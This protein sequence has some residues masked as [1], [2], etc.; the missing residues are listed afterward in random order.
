M[1]HSLAPAVV[2]IFGICIFRVIWVKTVFANCLVLPVLKNLSEW[3]SLL[4]VYPASWVITGTA[5]F[6]LY[7]F[8]S[9]R[10][11]VQG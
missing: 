3:T 2:T 9:R 8:V 5:M 4:I 6:I 10:T 7:A 1:G 11:F